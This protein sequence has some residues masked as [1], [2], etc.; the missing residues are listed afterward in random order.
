MFDLDYIIGEEAVDFQVNSKLGRELTTVFEDVFKFKE[1]LKYPSNY[2]DDESQRLY[3]INAVGEYVKEKTMPRFVKV[4]K[5]CCNL[6]V[7]KVNCLCGESYGICGYFAVNIDVSNIHEAMYEII[8]RQSGS[9]GYVSYKTEEYIDDVASMAN[10]FD[11][12]NSKLTANVFG[13]AKKPIYISDIYFDI[14]A[15]F[16]ADEFVSKDAAEP[17][18]AGEIAAIMMHEIGHAMST[19]EHSGDM[20]FMHSRLKEMTVN[21]KNKDMSEEEALST[22]KDID[23]KLISKLRVSIDND[24]FLDQTAK[25]KCNVLLDT[26]SMIVRNLQ[27]DDNVSSGSSLIGNLLRASTHFVLYTIVGTILNIY[28][29]IICV[30]L[31]THV[32]IEWFNRS[33]SNRNWRDEKL[34]DVG[35][36]HN[37]DFV[38][39]R[40]ADEFVSRH[41]Y[42][43]QLASGLNKFDKLCYYS[44]LNGFATIAMRESTVWQC[45]I[46][47]LTSLTKL[48]TVLC[49]FDPV[50]YEDQYHRLYRI[51]QNSYAI[52]K[53]ENLPASVKNSWYK[54]LKDTEAEVNAAKRMRDTKIG[55]AALNVFKSLTNPVKWYDYIY[56]G[57]ITQDLQLLED[58]LDD[59]LNNKLFYL[60]SKIGSIR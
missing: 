31:G 4:I 49:W 36:N 3:R 27:S 53:D 56:D 28:F 54:K 48:T 22:L 16:L 42:G 20:Y 1:N 14:N 9:H 57:N 13:K 2:T 15:A 17:F 12:H 52:F 34:S 51:A 37:R 7:K 47:M 60:G 6:D 26:I 18:T 21:L 50:Q 23:K 11:G 45:Y 58:N 46:S 5:D 41:G 43:S 29:S 10:N 44:S 35:A 33:N 19:I 40:W 59:M 55:S 24:A 30:V 39:E 32:W 8:S 38:I 25:N